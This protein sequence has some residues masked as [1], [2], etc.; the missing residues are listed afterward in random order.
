[1]QDYVITILSGTDWFFQALT[2]V[3]VL[4]QADTLKKSSWRYFLF[5]ECSRKLRKV[6]VLKPSLFCMKKMKPIVLKGFPCNSLDILRPNLIAMITVTLSKDW[7]NLWR[8]IQ[9]FPVS[10]TYVLVM[11]LKGW[12]SFYKSGPVLVRSKGK[13][14]GPWSGPQS[15]PRSGPRSRIM[16]VFVL[17]LRNLPYLIIHSY[18]QIEFFP[19]KSYNWN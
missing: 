1:M 4:W 3:P 14:S 2:Q 17:L 15:D 16:Q 5:V 10:N 19:R 6:E 7:G 13:W 11:L 9:E 8:Q 18:T 12:S